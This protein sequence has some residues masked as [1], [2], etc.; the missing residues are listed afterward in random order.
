MSLVYLFHLLVV[1][2]GHNSCRHPG[3]LEG[4][5]I[6]LSSGNE[7]EFHV[8]FE[9]IDQ[10]DYLPAL[11]LAAVGEVLLHDLDKGLAFDYMA[12]VLDVCETFA[13]SVPEAGVLV[14]R[15][16]QDTVKIE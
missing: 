12:E 14:L 3:L 11:L 9:I 7:F 4:R 16:H 13:S 2:A 5:E 8:P 10:P 15:V 1:G 6:L